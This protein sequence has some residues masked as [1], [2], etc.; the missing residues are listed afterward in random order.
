MSGNPTILKCPICDRE[1]TFSNAGDKVIA[2]RNCGAPVYNVNRPDNDFDLKR[3]Q[4]LIAQWGRDYRQTHGEKIEALSENYKDQQKQQH[5]ASELD[6]QLKDL[7]TEIVG[8]RNERQALESRNQAVEKEYSDHLSEQQRQKQAEVEV[9]KAN[10]QK[11]WADYQSELD[12]HREHWE[13]QF[14]Q[15]NKKYQQ[16]QSA[17]AS[18]AKERDL[19]L[20]KLQ[21]QELLLQELHD[22]FVTLQSN[23]TQLTQ[24]YGAQMNALMS[25]TPE[26]P[27]TADIQPDQNGLIPPL[28]QS[29]TQS[30]EQAYEQTA[31][32][33]STIAT[34]TRPL[35]DKPVW[36]E[37]YNHLPKSTPANA[38]GID[39][40]GYIDSIQRL[41]ISKTSLE[42]EW[43]GMNDF[44]PTFIEGT[45]SYW[46]IH[47]AVKDTYF[48]VLDKERFDFNSSNYK[49]I[50]L[51]YDFN[52]F[53]SSTLK[54]FKDSDYEL[55]EYQITWPAQVKYLSELN[56]WELTRK[57]HIEFQK[58]SLAEGG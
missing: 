32:P 19:L 28:V 38:F 16:L 10:Y 31:T 14:E 50:T 58:K 23:A 4:A 46:C 56:E 13:K 47:D 25:D 5:E 20:A 22:Q 18:L 1:N 35:E 30:Y 6:A 39:A 57:G 3:Y 55:S 49:S 26:I 53:G 36:L 52:D 33:S 7:Q 43:A 9:H 8:L 40:T 48:L 29:A 11:I 54:H 17:Q 44:S 21:Q 45:G 27:D 51:C 2:C 42:R 15:Q 37:R 41:T 34:A 12:G 24:A